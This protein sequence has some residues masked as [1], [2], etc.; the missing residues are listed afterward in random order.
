VFRLRK[1]ENYASTYDSKSNWKLILM[2]K[3]TGSE[4]LMMLT[5]LEIL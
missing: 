4:N 1:L 2:Q 3:A 5:F